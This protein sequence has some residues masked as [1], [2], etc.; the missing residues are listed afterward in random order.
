MILVKNI[1]E[2]TYS[3]T[4][5]SGLEPGYI[6]A[7]TEDKAKQ[8]VGDFPDRFE[9]WNQ[10]VNVAMWNVLTGQDYSSLTLPLHTKRL[11]T[12]LENVQEAIENRD[13]V[14]PRGR[15]KK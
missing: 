13:T 11:E 6:V 1:S 10:D 2:D 7:V 4:E 15:P 8:M 9:K 12:I 3:C 5:F 14:A